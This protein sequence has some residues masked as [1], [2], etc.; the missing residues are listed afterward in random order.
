[1][2]LE[3]VDV[4]NP[5]LPSPQILTDAVGTHL[6]S[7]IRGSLIHDTRDAAFNSSQGHYV[8]LAYEQAFGE[9]SYPRLEAEARQ[10]FT[11]YQRVDGQGKHTVLIRGQVGWSGD[12]TPIFERFF[13][14]GFQTFRGFA[15]RGRQPD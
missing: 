3:G 15:F 12:D 1:M 8:E 10:Y 14:G 13:A 9:Y 11:T 7:T 2:R 5:T 6:L 4:Y